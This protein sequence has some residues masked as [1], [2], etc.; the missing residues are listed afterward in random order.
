MRWYVLAALVCSV[1]TVQFWLVEG[2]VPVM[3]GHKT[4]ALLDLWSFEH[5]LGGVLVSHLLMK[6]KCYLELADWAWFMLVLAYSWE[7]GE[8]GMENFGSSHM[9]TWLDGAEHWS[10][11][12]ITDPCAFLFTG[13]MARWDR[14]VP[15]ISLP[16]YLSWY[17]WNLVQ[18]TCMTVQEQFF[19]RTA[20]HLEAGSP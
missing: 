2:T 11:R 3:F 7:L 6:R 9:R 20:P 14:R 16:L 15:W 1:A 8:C 19:S 12:L 13:F 4:K 10:N 18:P 5:A 17:G